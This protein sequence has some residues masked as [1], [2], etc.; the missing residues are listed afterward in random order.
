[1]EIQLLEDAKKA[2]GCIN[3]FYDGCCNS[4]SF[5]KKIFTDP[6]GLLYQGLES[7]AESFQLWG[8]DVMLLV[9]FVLILLYFFGFEKS[10]KWIYFVLV[11]GIFI[12]SF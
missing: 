4:V 12:S 6:V 8:A 9:L 2:I 7:L 5:F 11:L 1:M 10:K 3:R